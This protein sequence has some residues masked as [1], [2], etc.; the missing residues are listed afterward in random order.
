MSLLLASYRQPQIANVDK[1][2]SYNKSAKEKNLALNTCVNWQIS[3]RNSY[4]IDSSL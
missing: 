3:K 4:V 1:G 2:W